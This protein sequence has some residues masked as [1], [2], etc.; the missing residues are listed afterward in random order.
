MRHSTSLCWLI[1]ACIAIGCLGTAVR[2][3]RAKEEPRKFLEGLREHGLNDI[4]LEYLDRLKAGGQAGK[5]LKDVVDYEAGRTLLAMAQSG[6]V[7]SRREEHL[8]LARKKFEKFLAEH[9]NHPL[10]PGAKT[11]LANL[12]LERGRLKTDQAAGRNKTPEENK[13]LL[14][15]SRKLYGEAEK[16]FGQLEKEFLE[17]H[18]KFPK[19]IPKEDTKQREAREQVRRDLLD[20]RLKL[21]TVTYE[22]AKTYEEGAKQRKDLLTKAAKQY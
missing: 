21:A 11:Q 2:P 1:A 7:M 14:E 8:A 13:K 4:A 5:K 15:E 18:R 20:A 9:P 16:V 17:A 3:A 6:R 19:L 10:A 22:L 12:L